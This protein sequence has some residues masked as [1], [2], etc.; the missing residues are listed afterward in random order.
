MSKG[1]T[2]S[3][4]LR[5]PG[6]TDGKAPLQLQAWGAESAFGLLRSGACSEAVHPKRARTHPLCS[7]HWPLREHPVGW[8]L[9]FG[10]NH[11]ERTA[12]SFW[13]ASGGPVGARAP[14]RT[15]A[16]PLPTVVG[17]LAVDAGG[18]LASLGRTRRLSPAHGR[19]VRG[20]CPW[21]RGPYFR[22]L[23]SLSRVVPPVCLIA[24]GSV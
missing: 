4:C 16:R 5:R 7:N 23:N 24:W 21:Q 2:G 8:A 14:P 3:Q 15:S 20:A 13:S 18:S 1:A 11:L 10:K 12:G 19:G 22:W 9:R 6:S 17:M